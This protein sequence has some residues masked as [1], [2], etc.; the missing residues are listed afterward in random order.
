MTKVQIL[1]F[2][3]SC[4]DYNFTVFSWHKKYIHE[5]LEEKLSITIKNVITDEINIEAL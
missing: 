1:F 5:K 2:G 3:Q 4:K